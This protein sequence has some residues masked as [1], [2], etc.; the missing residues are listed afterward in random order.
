MLG[1]LFAAA[2]TAAILIIGEL[3]WRAKIFR[4]EN[5]RKFIHIATATYAA[6]WPFFVERYY[7]A[8]LSLVFILA[9]LTVKRL[10]I[11]KSIRAVKRSSYGE[12]WYAVSIGALALVFKQN[13]VFMIAV[14]HLALADGFAAIIGKYMAKKAVNF[15]FNR[16]RKSLAGSATFF[17]VSFIL[18]LA[19][20]TLVPNVSLDSLQALS[21]IFYSMVSAML[22]SAVEIIAP[23]GSDNVAVPFAAAVLLLAP[24]AIL[25]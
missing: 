8:G 15:N 18:N 23:K 12:I 14:L 6:F 16:S 7:I 17:I 4:G 21:P 24:L 13:Y 3:L 22:L 25:T 5:A 20:W 10:K 9:L 1:F 19:Y 2:G 11:F